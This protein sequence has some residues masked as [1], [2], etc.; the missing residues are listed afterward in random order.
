MEVPKT[1]ETQSEV[2]FYRQSVKNY[3]HIL[4]LCSKIERVIKENDCPKETTL[5][6][7]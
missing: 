5:Q 1:K 6:G 2:D 7:I 3:M 4:E